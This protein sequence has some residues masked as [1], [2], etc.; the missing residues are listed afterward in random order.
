MEP[1]VLLVEDDAHIRQALGLALADEGFAVADAVSG[2]EALELLA[3][4]EPDVVL[5]D[6][7]LPG[8]DG[9][10]VCRTLRARGDLPIIIV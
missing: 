5:L 10:E 2:E 9:L 3:D 6:L 8:V 7:M 4:A 1:S